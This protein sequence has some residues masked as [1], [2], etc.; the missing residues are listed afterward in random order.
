MP[1]QAK[2]ARLWLRP[3]SADREA[4]WVIL[5]RGRQ[6]ATGC[7]KSAVAEANRALHDY[8][9]QQTLTAPKTKQRAAEEVYIAE[10][11]ATYYTAKQNTVARSMALKQ[12]L[13]V[14]LDHWGER[15]LAEITTATC[16]EYVKS[17][18]SESAARRELEDLRSAV[19][20]AVADGICRHSIKVTIPPPPARRTAFFEPATLAKL[21]WAAHRATGVYKG[22][23]TGRRTLRHVARYIICATYTG[24]RAARIWRSSFIKKEGYPYV[25]V[26]NGLW[27]RTWEGENVP[28]NKRA[29]VQRIPPRLLAHLRR[30]RRM[31]ATYVCEYQGR[32]AD[33]KKAF[34]KLVRSV[35]PDDN[36]GFVRHTFRHTSATWLMQRG[37]DKF[38]AAGYLGMSQKTLESVYGHHHPDHQ[39]T[40]AD[41]FSKRRKTA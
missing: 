27:Y 41:A 22:K 32:P 1:R 16:N 4:T 38:E 20:M 8:L 31:G 40:V 35:F 13:N 36:E 37:A 9:T 5:H 28:K 11:V 17:R 30:W 21:L 15:S 6:I 26:V 39:S 29:P 12:R 34:A 23:S 10:V 25:D 19:N 14:L 33:S 3:K 18:R 24:S 7:G 2:P